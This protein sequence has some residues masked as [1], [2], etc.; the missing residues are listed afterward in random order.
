MKNLERKSVSKESWV[1]TDSDCPVSY[2]SPTILAVR[3]NNARHGKFGLKKKLDKVLK[4]NE[5]LALE[6]INENGFQIMGFMVLARSVPKLQK[7]NRA[8]L[9]R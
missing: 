4:H 5:T 1:G 6:Y 8:D 9:V 3:F 7:K 2:L